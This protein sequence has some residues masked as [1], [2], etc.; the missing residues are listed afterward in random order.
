MA[1]TGAVAAPRTNRRFLL[2]AAL[3]AVL[4]GSLFYA[5]MSANSGDDGSTSVAEGSEQVV[6]AKAGIKQRTKITEDMLELKAVPTDLILAGSFSS[7]DNVVGKVTRLPIEANGQVI[8]SAVVDPENPVGEALAQ[9][10][11]TGKRA[12]SINASQVRTAGGLVLPGDYVDVIW[13]CCTEE[14]VVVLTKTV[15]QNVQVL[16][17]AQNQVDAGPASSSD[18]GAGE[19][20]VAAEEGEPE[21]EAITATLLVTNEQAHHLIMAENTGEMRLTL[22]GVEDTT[23]PPTSGND[24]FTLVTELLPFEVLQAIPNSFW[25]EGYQPDEAQ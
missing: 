20:P 3:L 2:I 14:D 13:V 22:R 23:T 19:D 18:G 24:D 21:P 9:V 10:V 16:A 4:T 25:P 5:W 8:A 17:V 1:R 12:Y 6:V 7:L 15:V 11:P